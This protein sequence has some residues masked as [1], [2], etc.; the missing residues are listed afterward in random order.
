MAAPDL[1]RLLAELLEPDSDVIRRTPARLGLLLTG[2]SRAQ[3]R[4]LAA[5]LLRR[6]LLGRWKRLDPALRQRLPTLL[7][8][9]LERETEHTV[10]VVLAQL[11]ALVLRRGGL[12]AW[13]PLGTW[14]Q[15]VARDPRPPHQEAALL[16]LSAALEAAPQVLAPH[17]PALAALCRGALAPGVPPSPPAYSLQAL[18]G[19][20]AMLGDTHTELLRSL[21]PDILT[22]L[23]KLLDA[24]EERGT[25]ALEVLDE[26]LEAD[27]ATVTP[28]LRPLLDLC[29]Q[30]AG[31]ECWGDAVRVRALAT[32]TFLAQK[33]PKALLRGGLLGQV[34]GG[35]LIQSQD[36]SALI[37]SHFTEALRRQPRVVLTHLPLPPGLV[38]CRVLPRLAKA[39][40][41]RQQAGSSK[42]RT[43]DW[44]PTE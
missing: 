25:E 19:L 38:S 20:G 8:E 37:T 23:K 24:D 22:A 41:S 40:R 11:G 27:P 32:V 42:R 21:L 39:G 6:R 16:V 36:S 14:V 33:R 10:T 35:L 26:F 17:G 4:Q 34:L 29:V 28:H 2:S 12:S 5:V 1:E 18:G 15:E 30:V 13:G 43:S 44:M 9:A 31:D 3:I 7:A